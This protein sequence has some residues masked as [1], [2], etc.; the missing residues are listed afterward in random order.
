M[1]E[2]LADPP[3]RSPGPSPVP[4]GPAARPRAPGIHLLPSIAVLAGLVFV[5]ALLGAAAALAL[6]ALVVWHEVGHVQAARRLGLRPT[7]LAFLPFTRRVL[8]PEALGRTRAEQIEIALG[9]PLYGLHL[10]VPALALAL[11]LGGAGPLRAIVAVWAGLN[12]LNLLPLHPFDGGRIAHGLAASIHPFFGLLVAGSGAAALS[13]LALAVL[14]PVTLV[15]AALAV[16][17]FLLDYEQF[18]RW[19]RLVAEGAP[20]VPRAP[21]DEAALRV[22]ATDGMGRRRRL[23]FLATWLGLALFYGSVFVVAAF[24]DGLGAPLGWGLP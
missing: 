2:P 24:A 4:G 22:F 20:A 6:G 13:A 7:R 21:E 5:A 18:G 14:D 23:V 9:G 1:S 8:S 16:L 11:V 3:G 10:L 19:R 15:V 12:A 17:E